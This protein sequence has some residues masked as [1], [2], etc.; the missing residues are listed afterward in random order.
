MYA[1]RGKGFAVQ[2]RGVFS[3]DVATGVVK[4]TRSHCERKVHASST[5]AN[6]VV[7]FCSCCADS[8]SEVPGPQL[9]M[10]ES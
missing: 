9:E 5:K 10:L 6:D 1:V 7:W 3:D 4:D 8:H 2:R